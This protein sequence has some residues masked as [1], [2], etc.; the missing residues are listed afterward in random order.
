MRPGRWRPG[1]AKPSSVPREPTEYTS[2]TSEITSQS[3]DGETKTTLDSS[4]D[5]EPS[6]QSDDAA[7]DGSLD[8][9]PHER[10]ALWLYP[11]VAREKPCYLRISRPREAR[12]GFE[13]NHVPKLA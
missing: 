1:R 8:R 6:L 4:P 5:N 2:E 9:L 7:P 12:C 13:E 11:T 10:G 3:R